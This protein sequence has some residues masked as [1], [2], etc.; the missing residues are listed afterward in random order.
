MK[1]FGA[2]FAAVL[3]FGCG[4]DELEPPKTPQRAPVTIDPSRIPAVRPPGTGRVALDAVGGSA[5]VEEIIDLTAAFQDG[6]AE[7]SRVH[8]STAP[9]CVSPCVADLGY[10]H[11]LLRFSGTTDGDS[12]VSF[13]PLLVKRGN[14]TIL[15]HA[16]GHY[17]SHPTAQSLGSFALVSGLP[18][19]LTGTGLLVF[20]GS[21]FGGDSAPA[22]SLRSSISTAGGVTF[23]IG[24]GLVAVAVVLKIMGRDQYQ[25]GSTV[26]FEEPEAEDP[27]PPTKE[28]SPPSASPPPPGVSSPPPQTVTPV[29]R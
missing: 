13:A 11:H 15:R 8:L 24:A 25:P 18:L 12:N 10:G 20:G 17:R 28:S 27:K 2:G 14:V 6:S 3:L 16:L 23:G 22:Q 26:Q 29:T 1:R 5:Q 4:I 21:N 9:L 7:G 19:L